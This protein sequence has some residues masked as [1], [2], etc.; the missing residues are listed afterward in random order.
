MSESF[1][2]D[3]G[4]YVL[5]SSALSRIEEVLQCESHLAKGFDAILLKKNPKNMGCFISAYHVEWMT[6]AIRNAPYDKSHAYIITP[7]H[8]SCSLDENTKEGVRKELFDLTV[9]LYKRQ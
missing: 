9:W 1:N 3:L 2:V 5:V 7:I 6:G 8:E 4:H